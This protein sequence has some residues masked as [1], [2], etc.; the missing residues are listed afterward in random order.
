MLIPNARHNCDIYVHYF[1]RHEEAAGRMNR[2]GTIDPRE[3]Y[4]LLNATRTVQRLYGPLPEARTHRNTTVA[5]QHDNEEQFWKKQ[6]K[7]INRFHN[8]TDSEDGKPKYFPYR[9][10]TYHKSSLDNIVRQW[11]SIEKVFQLMEASGKQMGVQY[12]RIGMF[13]SDVM[14]LTPIDIAMLD[15]GVYDTTNQHVVVPGFA[16]MPV[17][18]RMIYGHY[19]G[20][21]IWATQRFRLIEHRAKTRQDPGFT[22]HSERFLNATVFPVIKAKG[23]PININRDICF[24]RT[25]AD[26]SAMVSDCQMKGATRGWNSVNVR[27]KIESIVRK[28]CTEFTMNEIFDFVGCG[29]DVEYPSEE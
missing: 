17:N 8:T 18:D 6:R 9:A 20:V 12:T 22:M 4:L 11:H 10:F 27:A 3:I 28:N 2:G 23:Y 25:R 26:E 5:F 13:R 7:Q 24:V 15:K 21:R 19:Q 16:Q 1:E 29:Q 14:Y